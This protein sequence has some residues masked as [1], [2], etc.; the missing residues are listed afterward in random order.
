MVSAVFKTSPL[1]AFNSRQFR[2]LWGSSL[3]SIVSFFMVLVTRG[4]IVLELTNSAFMVTA[5]NAVPMLP[6][7]IASPVGGIAADR[8]SRRL[9]LIIGDTISCLSLLTL[10][11]LV[12]ADV[13]EVWH[14]FALS[15][16]QGLA[17][18]TMMP[19]RMAI[20]P[21]LLEA[22]DMASGVAIFSAVFSAGMFVGPAPAG[23]LIEN[24]GI[25]QTFLIAAAMLVPAIAVLF[26][27][28]VLR[29]D[30]GGEQLGHKSI[31]ADLAEAMSHIRN[32]PLLLG[33]VLMGV[34]LSAVNMPYQ[35]VLPVFARDVLET[36]AAGLGYLTTAIGVGALVGSLTV[37]T[38]GNDR[39]L[40]ILLIGG[41]MTFGPLIILF[42]ISWIFWLSLLLG[43]LL[44]LVTQVTLTSNLTIIQL[45][46]P[47]H[48]RGRVLSIRM[49]VIG[50]GPVGMVGL[51]LGTEIL[52]PQTALGLMGIASVVL[53]LI[54]VWVFPDMRRFET[55]TAD[56][57]FSVR[58]SVR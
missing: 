14:I 31:V 10:G 1:R 21:D 49:I 41:F 33:L 38:A 30:P 54:L 27:V 16:L 48:L 26:A 52:G 25:G 44:G 15:F 53:T 4:W 58:P 45:T 47:S 40:R 34:V 28:N 51:G 8:I 29:P 55:D 35:A 39:Q 56:A 11:V 2:L 42:S 9:I 46:V 37:A 5:V 20:V 43:F 13:I 19:A 3:L 22:R 36:G 50:L 32:R 23:L 18:A 24:F 57:T 12:V 7:L 6:I 17:F